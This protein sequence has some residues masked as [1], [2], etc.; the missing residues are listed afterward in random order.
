MCKFSPFP[1]SIMLANTNVLGNYGFCYFSRKD[2]GVIIGSEKDDT[3]KVYPLVC[4]ITG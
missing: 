1:V 4:L 3:F 2:F